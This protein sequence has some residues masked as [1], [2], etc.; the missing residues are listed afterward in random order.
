MNYFLI[1]AVCLVSFILGY[2]IINLFG[3]FKKKLGKKLLKNNSQSKI[4]DDKI[5]KTESLSEPFFELKENILILENICESIKN[6][7]VNRAQSYLKRINSVEVIKASKIKNL[8]K[9]EF[10]LLDQLYSVTMHKRRLEF[11]FEL[12]KN[13]TINNLEL[14][15]K[16]RECLEQA[17][18]ASDNFLQRY[19]H[20]S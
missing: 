19:K 15:A 1:G 8:S 2:T 9:E 3:F 13:K 16:A 6:D 4:N 10:L 11:N 7:T 17:N 20:V 5:E 12:Y 18:M 14:R